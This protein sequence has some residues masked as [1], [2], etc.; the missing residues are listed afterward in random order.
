MKC[1]HQVRASLM[2]VF[3]VLS[4]ITASANVI[5]DVVVNY[6]GGYQYRFA[7]EFSDAIGINNTSDL[8]GGD[9]TGEAFSQGGINWSPDYDGSVLGLTFDTN[10]SGLNF[11]SDDFFTSLIHSASHLSAVNFA[12]GWTGGGPYLIKSALGISVVQ[13]TAVPEPTTQFLLATWVP[14]WW[15]V[16]RRR[17]RRRL[18]QSDHICFAK[19]KTT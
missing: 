15:A 19:I 7:M 18:A 12:Q 8:V 17:A 5:Y 6:S 4:P 1:L 11:I 13:R 10:N 3:L 16:S 9:F 14:V 2:L